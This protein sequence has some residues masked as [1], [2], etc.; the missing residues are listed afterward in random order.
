M[1]AQGNRVE[2]SEPLAHRF[3]SY[4]HCTTRISAE[5]SYRVRS[6]QVVNIAGMPVN[7]CAWFFHI[8]SLQQL[9]F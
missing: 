3:A 2:P 4:T 6:G 8:K 9:T 1:K 7:I 5:V